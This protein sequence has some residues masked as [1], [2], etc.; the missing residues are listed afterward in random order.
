[1]SARNSASKALH[2]T[3]NMSWPGYAACR[4]SGWR[5]RQAILT[6]RGSS[7][8]RPAQQATRRP[9][10]GHATKCAPPKHAAIREAFDQSGELSAAVQLRRLFPGAGD[11]VKAREMCPDHRR[12]ETAA[13]AVPGDAAA[14]YSLQIASKAN[15]ALWPMCPTPQRSRISTS[16]MPETLAKA[17]GGVAPS[18]MRGS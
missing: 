2:H 17:R 18:G 16:K 6:D 12:V 8:R 11:N 7:A 15:P 10:T 13:P 3:A 4:T 14:V 1:M 9:Q 5:A